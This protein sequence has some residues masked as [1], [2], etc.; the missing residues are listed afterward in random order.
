MLKK[1]FLLSLLA[2]FLL[3]PSWAETL[4]AKELHQQR[5]AQWKQLTPAQRKAILKGYKQ[6]KKLPAPERQLVKENFQEWQTLPQAEKTKLHTATLQY[7]KLPP[8]EK[9]ALEKKA[10]SP[11]VRALRK[12]QRENIQHL[13]KQD[14]NIKLPPTRRPDPTIKK[15]EVPRLQRIKKTP[16]EKQLKPRPSNRPHKQRM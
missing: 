15:H 9:K 10:R 6:Y 16:H 13:P 12:A 8:Q 2:L 1:I 7:R 11:E 14:R 4:N 3:Q 5:V